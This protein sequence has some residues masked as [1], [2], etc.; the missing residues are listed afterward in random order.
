MKVEQKITYSIWNDADF[1]AIVSDEVKDSLAQA[2]L[3]FINDAMEEGYREGDFTFSTGDSDGV[4]RCSW[5]A[6]R[7][8]DV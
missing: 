4:F 2:A 7:N 6:Q 5:T 1:S 8:I 3:E